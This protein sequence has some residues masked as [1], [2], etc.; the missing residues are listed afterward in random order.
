MTIILNVDNILYKKFGDYVDFECIFCNMSNL[1]K[2]IIY[3]SAD[4]FTTII[5][6][7]QHTRIE[8]IV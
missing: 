7:C 5:I 6:T 2:T 8:D 1:C 3:N 4:F